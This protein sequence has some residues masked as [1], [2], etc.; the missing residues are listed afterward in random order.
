M[1]FDGAVRKEGARARIWVRSLESDPKFLS[2]KLYF[3]CTNNMVEYEAL[4][5]G[6]KILKGLKAKKVHIYGN[7]ELIIN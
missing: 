2:Y 7:S 5:L 1:D 3:D 6:L 4:V